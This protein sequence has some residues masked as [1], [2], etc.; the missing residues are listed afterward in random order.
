MATTVLC[1]RITA[2]DAQRAHEVCGV[3]NSRLFCQ[4]CGKSQT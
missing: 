4:V 2:P 1:A 3:L